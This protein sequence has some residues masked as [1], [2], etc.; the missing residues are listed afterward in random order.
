MT[1][2]AMA[3]VGPNAVLQLT[4]VLRERISA[5][6]M[7]AVFT[8]AGIARYLDRPPQCMIDETEVAA[9]HHALL[10][11]APGTGPNLCAE[12]GTRTADYLLAN[13]IPAFAQVLL[14]LLPPGL[15]ARLLV[16]AIARNA[17]TFAGSGMFSASF[18]GGR[19]LVLEI[20]HNPLALPGCPWHCAVFNRLFTV[21]VSRHLRMT[22]RDCCA[23]GADSCRFEIGW[24]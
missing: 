3:K 20:A 17:W 8:A 15:A 10:R 14:R 21:L 2:P 7:I 13:R 18:P 5:S 22:H 9:L 4:D 16:R 6:T 12:A 11:A 24:V 1:T 23:A 19:K